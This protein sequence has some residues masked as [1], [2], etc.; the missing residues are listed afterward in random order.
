[1][2]LRVLL[3]IDKDDVLGGPGGAGVHLP[4]VLLLHGLAQGRVHTISINQKVQCVFP[5]YLTEEHNIVHILAY[6]LKFAEIFSVIHIC[7]NLRVVKDV[8]RV[9]KNVSNF[10]NVFSFIEGGSNMKF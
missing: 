6:R 1:M 8:G 4:P 10:S 2:F 7:K 3:G 5:P 9:N